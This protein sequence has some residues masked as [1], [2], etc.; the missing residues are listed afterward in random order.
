MFFDYKPPESVY[1]NAKSVISKLTDMNK[2]KKC[3]M[4]T[5]KTINF[6]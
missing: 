1:K 5:T 6:D 3:K 4:I 2:R